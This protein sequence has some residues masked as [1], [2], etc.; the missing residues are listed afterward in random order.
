MLNISQVATPSTCALLAQIV[1]VFFIAFT[2]RDSY[3][4]SSS[5]QD[6]QR[7]PRRA[8]R[9]HWLHDPRVEWAM[10]VVGFIV[11]EFVLV[12]GAAEVIALNSILVLVW[13]ALTLLF[14]TVEAWAAGV[15]RQDAPVG[16]PPS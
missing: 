6:V 12:L 14:A 9:W 3:V 4:T 5:R 15:A 2:L 16:L 7:R 13:F 10:V 8:R 1:P 11:Y